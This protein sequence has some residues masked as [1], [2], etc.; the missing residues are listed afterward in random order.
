[1]KI[2][3]GLI[4][5]QVRKRFDPQKGLVYSVGAAHPMAPA[6]IAWED[7]PTEA[8]ARRDAR[9]ILLSFLRKNH[10]GNTS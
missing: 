1:M 5:Y 7:G 2:D 4:V 9:S 6:V 10:Q 8:L 3:T